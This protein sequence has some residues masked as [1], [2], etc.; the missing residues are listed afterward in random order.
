MNLCAE[1]EDASC[2]S[3]DAIRSLATA[4]LQSHAALESKFEKL[5]KDHGEAGLAL[6]Q[7]VERA[8]KLFR[9]LSHLLS[10]P[11]VGTPTTAAEV[12]YFS[13]FQGRATFERSFR[14]TLTKKKKV[15]DTE[16]E[17]PGFWQKL[18]DEAIRTAA[19]SVQLRPLFDQVTAKLEKDDVFDTH[20]GAQWLVESLAK[21]KGGMRSA[22]L[23]DMLGDA[24]EK[25]MKKVENIRE[26]NVADVSTAVVEALKVGLKLFEKEPGVLACL[27]SLETWMSDNIHEI[28]AGRFVALAQQ[29]LDTK[30][31]NADDVSSALKRCKR[32]KT[33]QESL[34]VVEKFCA[35][36]YE[37]LLQEVIEKKATQQHM[38]KVLALVDKSVILHYP[39]ACLVKQFVMTASAL[40][41]AAKEALD[42]LDQLEKLAS[43]PEARLRKDK[44][45]KLMEL[46]TKCL[47][48]LLERQRDMS[49]FRRE[50]EDAV[51][52]H[53]KELH[54]VAWSD[55]AG[56][57][58]NETY[59]ACLLFKMQVLLK[60]M[61]TKGAECLMLCAGYEQGGKNPWTVD[62]T[63]ETTADDLVKGTEKS[64][65]NLPS[66]SMSAAC[67]ALS[68]DPFWTEFL[69]LAST[70]A[71]P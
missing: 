31:L 56:L 21:L 7:S 57:E 62:F 8:K 52:L 17:M 60:E 49:A 37:L 40:L 18:I 71:S 46:I 3:A 4:F 28:S 44:D 10:G 58:E 9:C 50:Q 66:K 1:A 42:A 20:A 65:K 43:S 19:S 39:E 23:E 51:S 27:Q 69:S 32:G 53:H 26:A 41:K 13:S 16:D 38:N 61:D 12:L 36:C 5:A 22:D 35:A 15:A 30:K 70:L 2:A 55:F 11:D 63:V 25:M 68:Q 64:L 24:Q 33:T 45:M 6:V 29:F 48:N 34:C 54:D 59:Q 67:E 14:I 47:S